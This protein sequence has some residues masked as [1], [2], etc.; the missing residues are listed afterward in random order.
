MPG[1][2][3]A[4]FSVIGLV[5]VSYLCGSVPFGLLVGWLKGVDIRT[6]GSCNI[7]ATNV[8]RVLGRP[9]GILVFFLDGLK[10]FLPVTLARYLLVDPDQAVAANRPGYLP[11]LLLV[12]VAVACVLGHMFPVWLKFKGGK[13]VASSLGVGLGIYPYYTVAGLLAFA[14]WGLVLGVTRYV[15]VAS[16]VAVIGFPVFFAGL[17]WMNRDEWGRF[18]D[19]WPLH[20]FCAVIAILVVYRHRANISR[21][22]AGTE[23][24]MGASSGRQN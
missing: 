14:L 6:K 8:G 4:W 1:T 13:G 23:H 19:L 10:G 17:A 11:F 16:I 2:Q 15:S 3:V 7:G 12:L 18:A 20:V 22:V 9:Y 21:L 24:K 5:A